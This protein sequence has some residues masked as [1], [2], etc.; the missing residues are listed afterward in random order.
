MSKTLFIVGIALTGIY[1]LIQ[2]RLMRQA[3]KKSLDYIRSLNEEQYKELKTPVWGGD[4][5]SLLGYRIGKRPETLPSNPELDKLYGV[6]KKHFIAVM[7]SLLIWVV[8]M[9]MLRISFR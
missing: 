7:A 6:Y 8:A 2:L 5:R 4:D 9:F 1:F 3:E